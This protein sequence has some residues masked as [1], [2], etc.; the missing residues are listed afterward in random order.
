MQKETPRNEK[1]I[2]YPAECTF[3]AVFRS[4]E[5]TEELIAAVLEGQNIRATINRRASSNGKFISYTITGEFP[6]REMLH[7]TCQQVSKLQ[8]YMTLF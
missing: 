3:K 7:E 8:G 1:E 4:S 6:S 5:K 2:T